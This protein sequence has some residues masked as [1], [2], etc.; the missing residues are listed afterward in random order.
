MKKEDKMTFK[1]DRKTGKLIH[2][3]KNRA[4]DANRQAKVSDD[5]TRDAL[6]RDKNAAISAL[7]IA[8]CA[9]VDGIDWSA[10]DPTVAVRFVGGGA[11]HTKLSELSLAAFRKV[12][13]LISGCESEGRVAVVGARW[14]LRHSTE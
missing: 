7:L 9:V 3:L 1:S 5:Q 10:D 12:R 4:F 6:Y 13:E 8:D 2:Q 14:I 11:L